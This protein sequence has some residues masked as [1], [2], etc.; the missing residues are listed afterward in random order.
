[1]SGLG[2]P[3]GFGLWEKR[4]QREPG[5]PKAEWAARSAGPKAKEKKFE[6]KIG[7]FEFTKVL[8]IFTRRFRRNFDM[9]IFPKFF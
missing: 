3:V 1:L 8:E 7:F 5:G 4:G 9:W 2:R 6:L